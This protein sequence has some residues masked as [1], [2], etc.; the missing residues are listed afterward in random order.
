MP[1]H[2]SEWLR[3]AYSIFRGALQAGNTLEVHCQSCK[4][5]LIIE[6]GF[7]KGKD[8]PSSKLINLI[9]SI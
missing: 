2:R 7:G 4:F 5:L 6:F 3:L 1:L 9:R 8:E